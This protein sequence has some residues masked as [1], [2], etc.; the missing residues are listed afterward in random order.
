MIYWLI[1]FAVFIY[2][3]YRKNLFKVKNIKKS[4]DT[5]K[6]ILDIAKEKYDKK[7]IDKEEYDKI[8]DE[9]NKTDE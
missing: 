1:I 8:K 7:E 9:F 4:P 6:Y 5:K 3:A 2:F